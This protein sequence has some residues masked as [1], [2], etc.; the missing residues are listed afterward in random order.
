MNR[1]L[2]A[3]AAAVV[4]VAACKTNEMKPQ[5][6]YI[7]PSQMEIADGRMTPEVLL[8]LG[9]LSDPQLSPDKKTILYGVSYTDI[10]ANRSVRNLFTIPVEGGD[11]TQLTM[12]GKSIASA[13]WSPDGK[14]IF[15]LQGGKLFEAPYENGQLGQRI[16][17][18]DVPGGID[19]YLLS[20]DATQ[21][22]YVANVHSAVEVPSDTD[23][24]LDKA[25]AYATE[26][27]MYRHWDHWM[28]EIPHS[29]VATLVNGVV[30]EGMDILGGEEIKFQLPNGPF[31]DVADL[32]WSPD[33]RYIAYSCKKLEGKQYAFSTNTCIYIYCPLTGETTQVTS[34]GGYDTH[35]VW[36]PDGQYLAWLSMERDG[37]EADKV[38]LM[39]GRVLYEEE[40]EGQTGNPTVAGIRDLTADFK[41]NVDAPVWAGDSKSLYFSALAEGIE[42]IF[43]IIPGNEIFRLTADTLWFD[44]GSPFGVLQD[45]TLLTTYMSMDFPTE[46]V[47][48]TDNTVKQLTYENEHLLG[49]LDK[50]ETE[51]RWIDTVDGQKMLTWVLFPPQFDAAKTYPA[52]EICLGGPQGTLSQGWSYRWNYMLM[53]HQGYV[54]VLPN[55]RGTTAFGQE[56]CEEISGDYIGLNMQDYLSAAKMIKAEPYV[57]GVAACGASYGGYSVYYLAGIHKNMYDCFIAHAGIFNE[58]HMYMTTEEMWFPNWDN[59]GIPMEYAYTEG[60]MGAAGDGVTF[61]GLQQAGSPWSNKAAAVRHYANSPHKLVQNWNTPILCIHGGS[62]F[63]VPYD[64]G[65]AAFNAAQ[66]MGVPSKL[67][68]FPNENHWILKPQN[69]LY[70]HRSYFDWLDRWMK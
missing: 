27:L 16:L 59:G 62:D 50:H 44:F 42:G 10:A 56:W 45:G 38:R 34:E 15:F 24:L 12:D 36:S 58:E 21:M 32:C 37:Y 9:R 60:Q 8:A 55:R 23:P 14:S 54:V 31:P 61:G 4:A 40:G 7:G 39:M 70:W 51:A 20:P 13:R 67:I 19:D 48:V 47:A 17:K 33:G 66:M 46:L 49:Q 6:G 29:Y 2:I 63:R 43:N 41:Y 11:P 52:I 25:E 53:A 1:K 30:K 18:A 65:M 35:P 26:D 5:E 3:L 68:V 64:E 22:I 69:A 57:S 28:T